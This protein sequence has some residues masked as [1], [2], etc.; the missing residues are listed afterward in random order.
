MT[1][2]EIMKEWL[3]R[4]QEQRSSVINLFLSYAVALL[5]LLSSIL[6]GSDPAPVK[7]P[8]YFCV[9]GLFALLSIAVGCV[10]VLIRLKEARLR[11]R[12]PRL[13]R[14]GCNAEE[15]SLVDSGING[16]KSWIEW[17]IMGQVILFTLA[18]LGFLAWL[19]MAHGEKLRTGT[20]NESLEP[21]H[22]VCIGMGGTN[23]EPQTLRGGFLI[24]SSLI[25]LR[26]HGLPPV[27]S[28]ML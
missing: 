4:A 17:L 23:S 9:S 12:M 2:E 14:E 16:L 5:G 20:A 18:L 22:T 19:Y 24:Q 1:D 21:H 8:I 26:S 27:R 3:A 11:A 13:R 28:T 15:I 25:G 6:L 10:L 7:S